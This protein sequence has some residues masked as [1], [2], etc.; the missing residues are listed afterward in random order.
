[1]LKC[2]N[3][4]MKR[5]FTLIELMVAVTFF[6]LVI[7]SAT[8]LFISAVRSQAKALAVQKLLDESSYV[9]EY[10]GRALRM[11]QKD[12]DGMTCLT[13]VGSGYN[14]EVNATGDSIKF[15]N[16]QDICQKFYLDNY[17]LKE[18][19]GGILELTSNKLKISSL[20]FHLSGAAQTDSLQPRAT[21]SMTIRKAGV[22][23][24]GIKIQ[25]T[26]SQRNL[27]IQQ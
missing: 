2:L 11:A 13:A 19:K 25:T 15:I 22:T 18:N 6:A 7:G 24:P 9:I 16:Y 14:Y 8:G 12:T 21:I 23:G 20:Q 27:D 26:I 10:M 1:M 4:K 3:A 17:Q 5:G